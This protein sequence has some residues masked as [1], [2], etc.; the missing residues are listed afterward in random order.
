M[1]EENKIKEKYF[2]DTTYLG[3]LNVE[4]KKIK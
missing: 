3:Y 2:N 1:N 4:Q